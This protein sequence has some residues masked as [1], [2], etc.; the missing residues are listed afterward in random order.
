MNVHSFLLSD[1]QRRH[2][3]GSQV[4]RLRVRL[5]E[6]MDLHEYELGQTNGNVLPPGLA[7]LVFVQHDD[8]LAFRIRVF[9]DQLLL[10]GRH[11]AA[12]KGNHPAVTVLMKLHAVEEVFDDAGWFLRRFVYGPINVEKLY[13]LA[14]AWGEL[15]FGRFTGRLP[16]PASGIS[17]DTPLFIVNGNGD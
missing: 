6:G 13:R 14:E 17:N 1:G 8:N 4:I 11:G 5:F 10:R 3:L 2:F 7:R 12:H 9:P 15:V 16:R